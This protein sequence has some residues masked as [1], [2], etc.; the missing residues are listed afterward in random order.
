M[1]YYYTY[2]AG[3][4]LRVAVHIVVL[5]GSHLSIG[6]RSLVGSKI[7]NAR[8]KVTS[9]ISLVKGERNA[10]QEL[11]SAHSILRITSENKY[12]FIKTCI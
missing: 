5:H 7:V 2:Q 6:L 10:C 12:T 11:I 4:I 3:L 1:L 8:Y 9:Q